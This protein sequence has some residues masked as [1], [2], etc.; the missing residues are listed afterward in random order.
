MAELLSELCGTDGAYLNTLTA[1]D[2]FFLLN[3]RPVGRC[4]HIWSVIELRGPYCV[5]DTGCTVADGDDLVLTVNVCYL[6]DKAVSL[7]ALK[8]LQRLLIGDITAHSAVDAVLGH[9]THAHA[10]LALYLARPLAAH[11]LLF[12]AGTDA[13]R[14]FVI[15]VQP[16]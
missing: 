12:T 16:V 2:A 15:F 10:E 7:S 4:G 1:G 8:Y 14:V 6:V 13:D 9:I 5:T 11:G 3:V